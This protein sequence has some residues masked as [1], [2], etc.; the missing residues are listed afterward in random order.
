MEPYRVNYEDQDT[1]I[2]ALL[3]ILLSLIILTY[4]ADRIDIETSLPSYSAYIY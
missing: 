1:V 2:I 3:I 4:F